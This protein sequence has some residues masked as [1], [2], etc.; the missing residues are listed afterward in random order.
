MDEYTVKFDL[1]NFFTERNKFKA[2]IEM[3]FENMRWLTWWT[4]G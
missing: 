3:R 4:R 1:T 2:G